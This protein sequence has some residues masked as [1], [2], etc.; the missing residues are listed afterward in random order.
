MLRALRRLADLGP[1]DV[2]ALRAVAAWVAREH[3]EPLKSPGIS[4]DAW[5]SPLA[6]L[7]FADRVQIGAKCAI[8]P[9]ASVWGGYEEAWARVGDEAQIGPG[10]LIVAGNHLVDGPGPVRRLGFEE[11]DATI[12][13]GAWVGA[14]AVVIAAD[15]GEGAVIGAGAVVTADVPARAVAVGVPAKVVRMRGDG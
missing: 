9:F 7:R 10:A 12:G 5:I 2:E 14:N 13:A 15:V 1:D 3:V 11:R 6:S 4:P 8:G